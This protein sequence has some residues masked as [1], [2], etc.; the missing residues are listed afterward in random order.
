M[1][2]SVVHFKNWKLYFAV[3]SDSSDGFSSGDQPSHCAKDVNI[4]C[5]RFETSLEALSRADIY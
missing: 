1:T 3:A 4:K 5:G 2:L